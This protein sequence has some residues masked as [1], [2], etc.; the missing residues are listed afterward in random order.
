MLQPFEIFKPSLIHRLI[1]LSKG[2]LVSQTYTRG[3]DHFADEK[4]TCILLSDYNDLGLAKVHLN[5]VKNDK[6]SA[7]LNLEKPEHNKKL[8]EMTS[9]DSKYR[10]FWAT[11]TSR[12][13]LEEKINAGYKVQ[14][15][16]YIEQHTN[17]RIDRNTTF[18]PTIQ[19][20]FGELF[21]ILKF[22]SQTLRIKFEE[23]EKV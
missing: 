10:L 16:K 6:Y 9:P 19:V 5:A 1:E 14:M 15:R 11:V 22:G 7:I 23:I 8:T 4:K 12:K 13:E 3:E 21:I 17:W 18:K 2:Y 20:T